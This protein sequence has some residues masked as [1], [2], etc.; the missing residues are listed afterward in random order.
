MDDFPFT[1]ADWQRVQDATL[2]VTNATLA[3]DAVLRAS[4]FAELVAVLKELRERYGDHPIL[5]ETEADFLDEPSLQQD[6]YRLAIRS[7]EQNALPTLSIRIALAR[8]LLE[9]F[10]EPKQA[11][12]EL[13]ACRSELSSNADESGKK[14]WYE[15]MSKCEQR[16]QGA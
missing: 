5:R 15:L 2:A 14:E 1:Q 4:H 13:A 11:A 12:R 7:A 3:D 8:V 6:V 9:D 10:A 16:L